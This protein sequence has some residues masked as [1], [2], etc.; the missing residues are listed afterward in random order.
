MLLKKSAIIL[1]L[2]VC[3]LISMAEENKPCLIFQ[4]AG[5]DLAFDLEKYNRIK[6][7]A[8]S[9]ELSHS[10]N[11]GAT[12]ELLYSAYNQFR[13]A[14]SK[15]T[16]A[17]NEVIGDAVMLSYNSSNQ[18]LELTGDAEEAYELG[19]FSLNGMLIERVRVMP[20]E[21]VS[22]QS[23]SDGVYIAVAVNSSDSITIKFVK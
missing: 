7:G 9:M 12:L 8:E 16:E 6:F 18:S 14:E 1:T 22:V 10:D 13:V 3:A 4:G 21:S 17:V 20:G 15:P 19:I 2:L 23:L 5:T 11:P